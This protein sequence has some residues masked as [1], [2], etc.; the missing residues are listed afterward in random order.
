MTI[1][2]LVVPGNAHCLSGSKTTLFRRVENNCS[3]VLSTAETI[4]VDQTSDLDDL[5]RQYDV[6]QT[7]YSLYHFWVA[8]RRVYFSL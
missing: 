2:T 1:H 4:V 8:F 3:G 5:C 7:L 6:P